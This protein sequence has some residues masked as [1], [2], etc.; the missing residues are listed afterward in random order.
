VPYSRAALRRRFGFEDTDLVLVVLARLE[1]QKGHA[2]LLEALPSVR[3]EFPRMR[4]VCVGDG[5]LR[6][7]LERQAVNLGLSDAVRFVGYQKDVAEWLAIA[8]LS[9][10]PSFYEGLPLVAIESLAAGCAMVAT[11]VDGTPE[12]VVNEKTGLTVEAGNAAELAEAIC[13]LL[14]DDDLRRSLGQT[15]QEWVAEHFSRQG[16]IERTEA[17]YLEGRRRTGLS[18]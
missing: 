1:P 17:L 9:V 3:R 2:V 8:D 18:A 16:Q 5:S 12:V 10:L 11:A 7:G 13:R 15:G 14:R 4:L 6:D